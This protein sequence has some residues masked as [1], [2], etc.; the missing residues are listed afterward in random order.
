[1]GRPSPPEVVEQVFKHKPQEDLRDPPS[2]WA[3]LRCVSFPVAYFA[4]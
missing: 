2:P 4:G 1:M 3:T